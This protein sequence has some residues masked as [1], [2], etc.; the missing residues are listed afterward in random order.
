MDT[1]PGLGHKFSDVDDGL[2]IFTMLNSPENFNILGLTICYGNTPVE[3]GYRLAKKYLKIA[4]KQDIPVVKGAKNRYQLGKEN[5]ASR[6]IIEQ[7]NE[8]P[9][10]I[11]LFILAPQ[12]NIATAFIRD[13]DLQD[14][15][16]EFVIMGGLFRAPILK[17]SPLTRFFD[18]RFYDKIK[19]NSL[20]SEFN[21]V[22]DPISASIVL[23]KDIKTTMFPLNVTS[24]LTITK[25]QLVKIRERNSNITNFCYRNLILWNAINKVI[26]LKGFYPHDVL[27]PIFKINPKIFT[28]KSLPIRIDTQKIRGKIQILDKEKDTIKKNNIKNICVNLSRT[29]FL[30]CFMERI[31]R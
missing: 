29:S 6:F 27:V 23:N 4:K 8:H 19:F 24:K 12:T 30:E 16:S 17:F 22:N 3:I 5:I 25:K 11:T 7:I 15:V 18:E 10:D 28:I 20:V 14:K 21:I 31:L 26:T 2:S 1:D 9:N 13:P